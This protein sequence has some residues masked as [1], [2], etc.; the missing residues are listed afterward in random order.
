MK[1]PFRF[2]FSNHAPVL[3][4]AGL[5]AGLWGAPARAAP[6]PVNVMNTPTVQ[7]NVTNGSI[8]V[9]NNAANPLHVDTGSAASSGMGSSCY[10]SGSVDGQLSC[11]ISTVPQ[12]KI[13]VI[14]TLMCTASVLAG[15]P[16]SQLI[17]TVGAPNPMLPAAGNTSI[18]NHFLPMTRNAS[19]D[20]NGLTAFGL[21]SPVRIYAF[22]PAVGNGVEIPIFVMGTVGFPASPS[23]PNPGFVCSLAGHFE[24]Q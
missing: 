20:L 21:I 12:G 18:T 9:R 6:T 7:A 15:T 1:K 4:A 22:G 13:L 3:V 2:A 11:Q 16:F 14:E 8:A 23:G 24:S 19:G 5:L 17:L 10:V